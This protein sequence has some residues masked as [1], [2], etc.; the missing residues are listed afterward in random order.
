MSEITHRN[1]DAN[2]I[3]VHLAEIGE[4]PL[5][6]FCHG[7]PESWYSWRHQLP[8]VAEAGFQAVA[9]DMRGYG[10]TSQPAAI[11]AYSISD[12]VADVVGV[13]AAVGEREAVVVGHDWGAPVAWYSALMRPDV[14][15]AV[16]GMSVPYIA[17]F[18][19]LPE[20]LTLNDLTRMNAAGRD[21]Y[22]LYFQPPDIA[23][24]ELEANVRRSMIGFMYTVSGDIVTDGVHDNGWD[25]HFPMGETFVDQLVIPHALPSWL[26]DADVDYYTDE[27]TRTGFRGGLNWYRNLNGIPSALAPF[28]GATINQPSLYLAGEYDMIAGNTES[29]LDAM[30]QT[31][32]GLRH[33]EIFDGAGHWIQ[34]ERAEPVTEALVDFL[35]SL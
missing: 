16:V 19:G 28:F 11:S 22:R 13:V 14:F 12:L 18:G 25:G 2:G 1:V 26:T 31:L 3:S 33:L 30:R 20:G 21:Y 17:P 23:E 27:L 10:R 6:L 7:F 15:R 9:M 34:Q 4:G 5:V 29:G 24:A 8:A 32:P 35:T